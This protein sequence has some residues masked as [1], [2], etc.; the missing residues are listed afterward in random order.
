MKLG[1]IGSR[2]R[3]LDRDR[4]LVFEFV[5]ERLTMVGHDELIIISG[6]CPEGA[7]QFAEQAAD[8]YGCSCTVH[9]PLKYPPAVTRHEAVQRFYRRNLKIVRDSETIL[10]LVNPGRTGGTEHTL[11]HATALGRAIIIA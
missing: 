3:N 7:D 10:A 4:L 11:R 6:G 1:I 5:K 8:L 9:Y 2:S